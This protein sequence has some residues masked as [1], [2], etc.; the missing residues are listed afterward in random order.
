MVSGSSSAYKGVR[1]PSP[2]LDWTGEVGPRPAVINFHNSAA[3]QWTEWRLLLHLP[4]PTTTTQSQNCSVKHSRIKLVNIWSKPQPGPHYFLFGKERTKI[5]MFWS[6]QEI[7][8]YISPIWDLS[9]VLKHR[10]INY[11]TNGFP[12]NGATV[13]SEKPDSFLQQNIE[14]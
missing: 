5:K 4:P 7:V 9:P 8:Q 11:N 3:R 13:V 1:S 14:K 10:N 2:G 12:R 6:E